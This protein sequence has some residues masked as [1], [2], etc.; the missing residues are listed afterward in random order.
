[1]ADHRDVTSDGNDSAEGKLIEAI[2]TNVQRFRNEGVAF[3]PFIIKPGPPPD[4]NGPRFP[5]HYLYPMR[6]RIVAP[7]W[8]P[9]RGGGD[10]C[11]IGDVVNLCPVGDGVRKEDETFPRGTFLLAPMPGK[12]SSLA[13]PTAFQNL[14]NGHADE[15]TAAYW[16]MLPPADYRALGICVTDHWSHPPDPKNY[17]CVHKDHVRS[18]GTDQYWRVFDYDISALL[19]WG[20]DCSLNMSASPSV[21]SVDEEFM[22]LVP[23][24]A[25]A[26]QNPGNQ[27]YL[28]RVRK[29]YLDYPANAAQRPGQDTD[30]VEGTS[31]S[32]GAKRIA[33]LPWSAFANMTAEEDPFLFLVM[34]DYWT[35]LGSDSEKKFTLKIGT[36]QTESRE[37]HDKTTIVLSSEAGIEAGGASA[38]FSASFTHEFEVTTSSS[39]KDTT[40]ITIEFPIKVPADKTAIFWQRQGRLSLLNS[41][42]DAV[43]NAGFKYQDRRQFNV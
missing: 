37:F 42:G 10:F 5:I 28:L 9:A 23:P 43:A 6:N 22:L 27:G 38:K 34:R 12:E 1:M 11:P 30:G 36:E 29:A 20:D 17:W 16:A 24:T 40:E 21:K 41:S 2:R 25:L 31:L 14:A 32:P 3:E 33:I 15:G 35:C 19:L 13:H 8:Y 39:S 4:P 7:Y 18:T 26:V